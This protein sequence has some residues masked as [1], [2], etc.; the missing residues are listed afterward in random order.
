MVVSMASVASIVLLLNLLFLED[1]P[2]SS[3]DYSEPD[4]DLQPL[5]PTEQPASDCV[6]EHS[7]L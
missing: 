7:Q 5:V 2:T 1:K 6:K 3:I 4:E